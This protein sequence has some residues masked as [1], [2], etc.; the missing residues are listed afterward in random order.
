MVNDQVLANDRV[1]ANDQVLAVAVPML[2]MAEALS[3][4]GASLRVRRDGAT[5]DP[6]LA[7]RLDA[8]LR[9]LGVRDA[10]KSSIGI[11]QRRCWGIAEGFLAID[12]PVDVDV[13]APALT[14]DRS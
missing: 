14:V 6:A 13:P 7:A 12:T 5:V 8:V 4:L 2:G 9:A 10:V 11:R 3:A 1:L